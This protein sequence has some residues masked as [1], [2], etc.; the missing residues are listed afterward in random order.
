MADGTRRVVSVTEV[1]GMDGDVVQLQE[2]F[3]FRR[4]GIAP[5]GTVIGQFEAT[6]VRPRFIE[7]LQLAGIELPATLFIEGQ[8]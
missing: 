4:Q 3:R 2:I 5:D 6:G 1:T 8:G 7:R